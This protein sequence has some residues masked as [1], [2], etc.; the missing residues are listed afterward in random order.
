VRA[1]I[2]QLQ[3]SIGHRWRRYVRSAAVGL[4]GLIG[5][6]IVEASEVPTRQR[7][8]D[9]LAALLVGGFVAWFARDVAA[10]VERLRG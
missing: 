1:G 10:L 9:I 5:I 3:V 6:A 7:G 4:S 2:D 8:L